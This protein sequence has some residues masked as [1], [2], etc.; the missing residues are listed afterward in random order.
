MRLS[1]CTVHLR[2]VRLARGGDDA[3][4]TQK[5][6]GDSGS[7]I[8]LIL[9]L[10][11]PLSLQA[12]SSILLTLHLLLPLS[13]QAGSSILV[14]ILVL[15]LNLL[16]SLTFFK[17]GCSVLVL[18]LHLLLPLSLQAGSGILARPVVYRGEGM[19]LRILGRQAHGLGVVGENLGLHGRALRYE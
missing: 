16:F 12:G 15:V 9:H 19:S 1:R 8:L 18:I 13:L 2:D 17:T 11:L 14:L 4:T 6:V 10:L 3:G 7:S 5:R